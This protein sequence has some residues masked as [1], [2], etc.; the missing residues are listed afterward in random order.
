MGLSLITVPVFFDAKPRPAQLLQ[1]FV[2]LYRAGHR[3]MPTMAVATCLLYGYAAAS[4]SGSSIGSGSPTWLL[5]AMAA[6][7][8]IGMVPFTWLAMVPTNNALFRLDDAAGSKADSVDMEQVK[9]L[10]TRWSRLH[11]VRSLF[12]LAGAVLG[13]T[14]LLGG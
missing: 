14:T 9:V 11:L 4:S 13:L 8:T 7:T 12:P 5:Y 3:V 2:H 6:A 10:L 1:Q